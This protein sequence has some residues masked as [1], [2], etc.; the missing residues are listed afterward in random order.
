MLRKIM[1]LLLFNKYTYALAN[2]NIKVNQGFN[3]YTYN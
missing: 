1:E 3:Q 2:N